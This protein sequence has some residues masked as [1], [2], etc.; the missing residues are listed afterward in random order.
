M[1]RSTLPA[2]L[3]LSL[4]ACVGTKEPAGDDSASPSDSDSSANADSDA[5]SGADSD[6]DSGADSGEPAP[7]EDADGDGASDDEDCDDGDATVY[8]GADEI[9]GDGVINDCDATSTSECTLV[10]ILE[11]GDATW[12]LT[13]VTSDEWAGASVASVGDLD[14]D[15]WVDL[16]IGA[17]FNS[18]VATDAGAA[19]V[20]RGGLL[21]VQ[22]SPAPLDSAG[23]TLT[24]D[25][26]EDRAGW[27]VAGPGD[28]DGDGYDDLLVSAPYN[29]DHGI[30]S[31][32]VYLVYGTTAMTTAP[33]LALGDTDLQLYGTN[34]LA[35]HALA[36]AG[37]VDG[38]G[39]PELLIGNPNNS[40]GGTS[41]GAAVMV[42]GLTA[43]SS[44]ADLDLALADL[45][46]VGE[47]WDDHA[48]YSVAGGGDVDGDG[49]SDLWIGA[50][51]ADVSGSNDG[52]AYLALSGSAAALF[53]EVSLADA[54][55]KLTGA[56]RVD[57][58]GMKV[59]MV[60]DVDGDGLDDLAVG[61][62]WTSTEYAGSGATFLLFGGSV[63]ALGGQ[64]SAFASDAQLNGVKPNQEI[65]SV[66]AGAGDVDAD[67]LADL[68][69]GA[70]NNDSAGDYTGGAYLLIGENL[71]T[72]GDI[73][74]RE[75]T[76]NLPGEREHDN[77]GAAVAGAGDADG[78]GYDDLLI[79]A[80]YH[81][82]GGAAYL[83][84][85]LRSDSGY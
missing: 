16:L 76:T 35:G 54:D 79:G 53:R 32:S 47:A 18:T 15:G 60:G 78:D 1:S 44:G 77:A 66:L 74:L 17:Y 83:V 30:S 41:T 48:G 13:S 28:V 19:Y 80:K 84:T 22:S 69:I 27:A 2:L 62:P 36:D 56:A 71:R 63:P 61:A 33:S 25:Q 68:L 85:G 24:G 8:P 72:G 4:L 82:G 40:A 43:A 12:K 46:M 34:E 9:C 70:E 29:E 26:V 6:A 7:I 20:V 21:Q 52:A 58:L 65:G 3:T 67:G 64:A 50:P 73:S 51:E 37:D 42:L 38:D 14:G 11:L 59:A 55:L 49:L 81:D 31:G 39:L 5:D 10:D 45:T 75:A 57:A 23:P